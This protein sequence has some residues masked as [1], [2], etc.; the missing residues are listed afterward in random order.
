L[1]WRLIKRRA[2]ER[3]FLIQFRHW[4]A[5]GWREVAEIENLRFDC[6]RH[7]FKTFLV[8][9]AP[10]S[11]VRDVRLAEYGGNASCR[12]EKAVPGRLFKPFN[13]SVDYRDENIGVY[14]RLLRLDL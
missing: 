12:G 2:R 5:R 4:P 1:L 13:K 9:R 11:S 14:L 7:R 6:D 8:A 3:S 10:S